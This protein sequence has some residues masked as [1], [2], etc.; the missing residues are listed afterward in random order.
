[1]SAHALPTLGKDG[2]IVEGV[3]TTLNDDDSV[4]VSPMGPIVGEDFSQLVL[5]P[6]RSST[7]YRNLKRRRQGV[8]HVTD[9]VELIARAAVNRLAPL[10]RTNQAKVVAGQVLVDTCRCYEVEVET[11]DDSSERCTIVAHT[12]LAQR[13][14]D[15]LGFN[16][17]QSAVVEAA[18]LATRTAVLP[19]EEILDAIERLIPQVSKTGA[20]AEQAAFSF[21]ADFI[22]SE[23]SQ[24]SEHS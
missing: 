20:A 1:M 17:A 8:F 18:I 24:G 3:M 13:N 14:R 15:F 6:F 16:R 21:L 23:L 19:A 7:T 12:V 5:R 2:R 10:P 9:D 11:I 4:N 22:R